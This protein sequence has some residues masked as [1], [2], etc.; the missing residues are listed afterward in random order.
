[1]VLTMTRSSQAVSKTIVDELFHAIF[2]IVFTVLIGSNH[3]IWGCDW[4]LWLADAADD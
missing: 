3:E 2:S 4:K 1:M